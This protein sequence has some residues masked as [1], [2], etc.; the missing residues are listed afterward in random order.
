[1]SSA[2]KVG[3]F[4]LVV[5]AILA[6]FI[7]R[8]EDISPSRRSTM[9]TMV[10]EFDS[11]AGLNDKSD[12][13]MAGVLIGKVQDITLE[14][15]RAIVT[16]DVENSV[17]IRE[18]TTALVANLGL[19][20]EKYIE[21]IPGDP[22]APLMTDLEARRIRGGALA[23]IDDVTEQISKIAEDVK[24]V[25]ASLRNAMGGP[26]GE[27]RMEEIVENLRQI[28]E[29]VRSILDVNEDNVNASADNIRR[30][31]EDLRVEIPR[32]ANSIDRFASS[33]SDTVTENREDVRVVVENLR[34]LSDDLKRTV[35]N[36]NDI[37]GQVK[38]GEGTVG[39]LIY[40]DEAHTRL[41]S[42]LESVETGVKDLSDTL[43]RTK[44][45]Q[46]G[47]EVK[48]D[49]YSGMDQSTA[50][51]FGDSSRAGV[52]LILSPNPTNNRFL[53]LELNSDPA[54]KLKETIVTETVTG[55]D[56]IPVTT[57]TETQ[58][59]NRDFVFSAQA[60]WRL[61]DTRIRVGVFDGTGGIA[62][63][64]FVNPRLSLS[65]EAYDFG[66]S[67]DIEPRLRFFGRYN[68]WEQSSRLPT[69]FVAAGV[70]NVL[71]DT[72]FTFGGGVRW[73]D[74]DLKYLLGSVPTP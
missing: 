54:G 24:A 2:A 70:D 31:T 62:A 36:I 18:G 41:T 16:L 10:L 63:D 3:A 13:R 21:L 65:G 43:G 32:I 11:V 37:T 58:R 72:A 30:I 15:G 35:D 20:G 44:R 73:S 39:K 42:A 67:D 25:T 51:G 27:Q 53:Q 12:V 59:Y 1:M 74:D 55:P 5:L 29:R 33:V 56:G 52:A 28:T 34:V 6:F 8:I 14:N 50:P 57:T 61:N 46:L 40:D 22:D 26:T 9:K 47:V 60:G 4:M 66:R 7:L 49:F 69:I 23:S 19:L 71:N 17:E 64:Y 68:V 38:S 45:I 48:G